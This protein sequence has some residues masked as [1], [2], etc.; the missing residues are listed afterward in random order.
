MVMKKPV[1]PLQ[2]GIIDYVFSAVLLAAPSLLKL[3]KN[4][5]KTYASLG[6][7]FLAGNVL[8]DTPVGLKPILS[9]KDHQKTDA[10]F[11]AGLAA[12]TFTRMV[13]KEKKALLFHLGFF[14]IAVTHYIFTDYN[15]GSK[16]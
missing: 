12:L 7:S 6:A 16:D 13:R 14:A 5:T 11:L 15:L 3:N 1:T 10:A 4:A 9:F 8:T 2:H